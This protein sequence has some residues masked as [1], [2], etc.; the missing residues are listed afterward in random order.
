MTFSN[1]SSVIRMRNASAASPALDTSTST[2]PWCAS[3]SLKARSTA[4]LSVTSHS[5]PNSPSGAPDPR[6]VT[7]TLW[8]SAA[9]RCAIARPIPRFPPVTRTER[10]T[11]AGLPPTTPVSVAVSVTPSTYRLIAAGPKSADRERKKLGRQPPVDQQRRQTCQRQQERT[12][13]Q[14]AHAGV[15][16]DRLV[17]DLLLQR[18]VHGLELFQARGVVPTATGK[19]GNLLHGGVVDRHRLA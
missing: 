17:A 12:E 3:T 1:F 8:P 18:R 4:S 13:P 15:A 10:D 19:L 11:N 7:A 14:P 5:T 16:L 6:C 2:G 9:S